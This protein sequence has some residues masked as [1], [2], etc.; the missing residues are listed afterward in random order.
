MQ[1]NS[2]A[3]P[4]KSKEL[5]TLPLTEIKLYVDEF[6]EFAQA[7]PEMEFEVTRVGCGLAGFKDADIAPLFKDA[8]PNCNLP[9]GWREAETTK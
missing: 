5:H 3:I 8:P 1:G 4:T 9:Q 6:I 7:Q 2:Y